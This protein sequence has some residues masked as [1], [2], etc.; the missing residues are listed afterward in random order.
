[1]TEVKWDDNYKIG[2]KAIDKQHRHFIGLINDV[3]E[4]LESKNTQKLQGVIKDLT[5]YAR[6]HF[7]TEEDY[8]DKFHY[9]DAEV[10]KAAHRELMEKVEAFATRHD[11]P[12]A[13]G[14]DLLYFLEKWLLVHFRG[15]DKKYVETFKQ[16][17]VN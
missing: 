12:K 14:F 10:H 4:C 5:D 8:F 16:N 17:G 11:D 15:M 9:I 3:Y 6:H 13:L 7:Q 1:M 2:V